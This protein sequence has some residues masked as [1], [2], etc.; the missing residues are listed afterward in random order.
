[1]IRIVL[2]SESK[3]KKAFSH[4]WG[5]NLSLTQESVQYLRIRSEFGL[6]LGSL[7]NHCSL[8][9]EQQTYVREYVKY[10]SSHALMSFLPFTLDIYKLVN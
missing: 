8:C 7:S 5:L 9:F 1:M 6:L 4:Q 2:S 10:K 3:R